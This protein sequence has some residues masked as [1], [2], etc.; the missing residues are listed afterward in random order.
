MEPAAS[1][2]RTALSNAAVATPRAELSKKYRARNSQYYA[3]M[4]RD[5]AILRFHQLR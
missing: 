1:G 3:E 4:A 5:A 2:L